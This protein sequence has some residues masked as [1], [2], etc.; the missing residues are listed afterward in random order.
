MQTTIRVDGTQRDA[1]ARIAEERKES[2]DAALKR[3]IWE[4]DCTG[5]LARL[6]GNSQAL[7]DYEAETDELGNA[8]TEVDE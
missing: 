3:L 7:A 6:E 2:L 5:S 4:H 8:A 1:L